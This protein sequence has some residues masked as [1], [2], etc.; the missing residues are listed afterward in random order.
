MNS[1]TGH[2][3]WELLTADGATALGPLCDTKSSR[4]GN[5]V[6]TVARSQT[7]IGCSVHP[8]RVNQSRKTIVLKVRVKSRLFLVGPASLA[9]SVSG[10]AEGRGQDA[11]GRT[12]FFCNL[13]LI[14]VF[15]F[16][17]RLYC[18]PTAAADLAVASR[19]VFA[20]PDAPGLVA[21]SASAG[22]PPSVRTPSLSAGFS[23]WTRCAFTR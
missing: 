1:C 8:M 11:R 18:L 12:F 6:E 9:I 22:L 21:R 7:R 16:P 20:S 17:P 15:S 4:W 10:R 13:P 5:K 3:S 23:V 14:S 2:Q 19:R